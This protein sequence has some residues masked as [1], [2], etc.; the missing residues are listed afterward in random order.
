[1]SVEDKD[2]KQFTDLLFNNEIFNENQKRLHTFISN[3]GT[4]KETLNKDLSYFRKYD[5]NDNA[6]NINTHM[7]KPEVKDNIKGK[8][9]MINI[10]VIIEDAE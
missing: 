2:F 10:C 6:E 9:R 7:N 8:L 1:M 3:T 5:F 4:S